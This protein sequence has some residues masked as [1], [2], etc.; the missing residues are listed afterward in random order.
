MPI[1]PH[2]QQQIKDNRESGDGDAILGAVL[3]ATDRGDTHISLDKI[4]NAT[5]R[6]N[7]LRVRLQFEGDVDGLVLPNRAALQE[8]IRFA[9][10]PIEGV[11]S[12]P[13]AEF[14]DRTPQIEIGRDSEGAWIDLVLYHGSNRP[15]DFGR[16]ETAAIVFTLSIAPR[17]TTTLDIDP[18]VHSSI[19]TDLTVAGILS[20]RQKWIRQRRNAES[21]HLT[22]PTKPLPTKQQ[23]KASYARVGD[24][25][26][27]KIEDL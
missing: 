25:N 19:E 12:L 21:L 20:P 7:D 15:F 4:A 13:S 1:F 10:G 11:F 23:I 26:P 6:A 9:S 16:M 24:E 8:A 17:G 22:I 3:F 27:W 5:I 14:A 18:A 2:G